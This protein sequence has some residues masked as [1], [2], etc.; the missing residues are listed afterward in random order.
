MVKE[1]S[2]DLLQQ[3]VLFLYRNHTESVTASMF[4]SMRESMVQVETNMKITPFTSGNRER[5]EK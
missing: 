1:C 2:L 4:Y 3:L 5:E